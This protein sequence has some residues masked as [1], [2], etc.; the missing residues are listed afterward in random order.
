MICV[1]TAE[2]VVL[3]AHLAANSIIF[4]QKQN[5]EASQ[6]VI[7][8]QEKQRGDQTMITELTRTSNESFPSPA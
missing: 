7:N 4:F 3:Q 8:Y 2:S 6:G 5:L 1:W